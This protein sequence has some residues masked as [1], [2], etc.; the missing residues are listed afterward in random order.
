MFVTLL[1]IWIP[2]EQGS[3]LLSSRSAWDA[4]RSSCDTSYDSLSSCP[5][6]NKSLCELSFSLVLYMHRKCENGCNIPAWQGLSRCQEFSC[7]EMYRVCG[8][9]WKH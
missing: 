1:A 3:L 2:E 8:S 7:P 4:C 5:E 6:K 9:R